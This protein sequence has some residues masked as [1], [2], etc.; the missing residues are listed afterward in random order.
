MLKLLLPSILIPHVMFNLRNWKISIFWWILSDDLS[1]S[2][3]RL[4]PYHY[5]V[6]SARCYLDVVVLY[7]LTLFECSNWLCIFV[8]A[9]RYLADACLEALRLSIEVISGEGFESLKYSWHKLFWAAWS[10]IFWYFCLSCT[11]KY[12]GLNIWLDV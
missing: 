12:H 8:V 7:L 1:G 4:L 6:E 9:A 5:S 3:V 10:Y 11:L 2:N